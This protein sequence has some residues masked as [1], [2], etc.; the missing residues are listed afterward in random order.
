MS[1]PVKR[2]ENIDEMLNKIEYFNDHTGG[3]TIDGSWFSFEELLN[4][5]VA[6]ARLV[7]EQIREAQQAAIELLIELRDYRWCLSNDEATPY[8]FSKKQREHFTKVIG[9]LDGSEEGEDEAL[10]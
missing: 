5:K 2:L 4:N 9:L 3:T 10:V 7:I 1:D 8:R 6:E